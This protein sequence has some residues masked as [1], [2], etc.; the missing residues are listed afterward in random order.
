MSF[1][2]IEK[3]ASDNARDVYALDESRL[4]V[5]TTDR[6]SAFD[7]V[8]PTL[9]PD[10]GRALN[11]LSI[12]WFDLTKNIIKNHV[13]SD[14]LCELPREFQSE[15]YDGRILLVKRL[16]MVPFGCIV[17]GYIAGSGWESYIKDGA[18]CGIP[19]PKGLKESQK[20]PQP[21]FTPSAKASEGPDKIVPFEY[22]ENELGNELAEK[23]RDVSLAVYESCAEYARKR[24]IIIADTK[25]EFGLDENGELVLAGEVLTPDSSRFWP[26][27]GYAPGKSQPSYDKQLVRDWLKGADSQGLSPAPKLPQNV[28]LATRA[29]YI[30]AYEVLTG[31]SW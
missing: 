21:I 13:I 20:L 5:V 31:N 27:E 16:K 17:R 14:Q 29:K 22:M 30:S 7:V 1:R 23:I 3:I 24:G 12:F 10:K 4:V 8:L 15:E 2:R 11:G 26:L 28:V 9:I 18:V 6:I 19:L 25:F